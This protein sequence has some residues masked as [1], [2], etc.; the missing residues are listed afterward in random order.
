[1]SL[2][3][4]EAAKVLRFD[5]ATGWPE[6][7]TVNQATA[8]QTWHEGIAPKAWGSKADDLRKLFN[9]DHGKGVVKVTTT[10]RTKK[11]ERSK[12]IEIKFASTHWDGVPG[13]RKTVHWVEDVE[14]KT[15]HITAEAFAAW[16][17]ANEIEPSRHVAAW[18]KA[19]TVNTDHRRIEAEPGWKA[20]SDHGLQRLD[21][22]DAGRLVRLADLVQWLMDTRDLPCKAAVEEVCSTFEQRPI[23]AAGWLYLLTE[24]DYA[25]PL[26]ADH[27]FSWESNSLSFWDTASPVSSAD[28]GLVG[29]IKYTREYWGESAEPGAGKWMGQQVL[30]PLA[31]RMDVANLLWDYG[32]RVDATEQPQA[33]APAELVKEAPAEKRR[34]FKKNAL[35]HEL[36]GE[37]PTIEQD[38][39]EAS[40]NGLKNAAKAQEH[41]N[42]DVQKARDWA[43]SKGKLKK[44]AQVVPLHAAWPGNVTTHRTS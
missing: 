4:I 25:R 13:K 35:V 15:N 31:I 18:F 32:R 11:V 34:V 10:S 8:L 40:R 30:D 37:W 5:P 6:Q 19:M 22:T 16:L 27:S 24:N 42:W 43:E 20:R 23:G 26:P 36:Q 21:N 9:L 38:L 41:G 29:A 3:L 44:V 33:T 2:Q 12:N 28:K 14:V 7:F 39:S 17:A 1:M